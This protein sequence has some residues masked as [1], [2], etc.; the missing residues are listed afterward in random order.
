MH[1]IL[2]LFIYNAFIKI[3]YMFQA[4]RCSSTG[5]DC[6]V[7]RLTGAQDSHLQRV[8]ISDAA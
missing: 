6:P 8:T 5:D 1:E 2:Y 4:V 3:L 7:H